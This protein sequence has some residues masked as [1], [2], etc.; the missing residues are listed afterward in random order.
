[1][2]NENRKIDVNAY[3]KDFCYEIKSEGS[4][5]NIC[6]SFT[7]LYYGTI[8]AIK[9]I[10]SAKDS[11]G[12]KIMLSDN[13][14][15]EI[16]RIGL[17]IKCGKKCSFTTAL[18]NYDVK[19]IELVID[20]IVF[21]DG[22]IVKPLE[23]NI[24]EYEIE[25]LST[26]W[27]PQEHYEK[28]AIEVMKKYNTSS[29]CFPKNISSGWI[30]SC[31]YL[32][33]D[34]A[35]I[36]AACGKKKEYIFQKCNEEN[37]KKEI[38]IMNEKKEKEE[39]NRKERERKEYE[40]AERK[41]RNLIIV[42][43]LIIS[44][45]ILAIII[46]TI[47]NNVKYRLT[48]ED[49]VKY[50]IAQQNY[51]KIECFIIGLSNDFD[52]ICREYQDTTYSGINHFSDAEKNKDY[53]Y[54]R[55]IYEGS[56]LLYDIITSQY[57][58]KYKATYEKLVKVHKGD[59]FNNVNLH[60]QLYVMNSYSN[61]SYHDNSLEIDEAI[62]TLEKY[63]DKTVFNPA[64]VKYTAPTMPNEDY[65]K[66][67]GISLGIIFYDDGN[68]MYIGE[69]KDGLPHGFGEAFYSHDESG[70][71]MAEGQ[72]ENGVFI[73]GN[74]YDKEGNTNDIS[75]V[76]KYSFDGNCVMVSGLNNTSSNEYIA[77]KNKND[78]DRD[79]ELA[80]VCARDYLQDI[81]NKKNGTDSV[82]WIDIPTI[83][84][85]Y[86]S[87]SVTVTMSDGTKREGTCIV[88]KNYDGTFSPVEIDLD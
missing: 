43:I 30:C 21:D 82:Q 77:N 62:T 78:A 73:S 18:G 2:Y 83:S 50:E 75:E 5:K 65:S 59:I 22:S 85:P 38:D 6:V 52:D 42:V 57:P 14:Y 66:V 13:E 48:K 12:D 40:A 61:D 17:D 28:D 9:L 11:F 44:S 70:D 16:K 63:M 46:G 26:I 45:V 37:V 51:D 80:S 74:H 39:R 47:V 60:E 15:F 71:M 32:N 33:F 8:S 27:T 86:Y 54:K 88:E 81:C 72:F 53:L 58:D 55:G 64:K 31:G 29:I 20:Q 7:N 41:S 56:S 23:E 84:G 36:C 69:I 79:K 24:I 19:Q 76:Q 10:L 49:F 67:Y 3:V 4:N 35:D 34:K 68:I 1:M 25:R 87:Y